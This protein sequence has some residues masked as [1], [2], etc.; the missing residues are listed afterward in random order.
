MVSFHLDSFIMCFINQSFFNHK[1]HDFIKESFKG[2]NLIVSYFQLV[3]I[4]FV[5]NWIQFAFVILNFDFKPMQLHS[6]TSQMLKL[7][8][9][10]EDLLEEF[11]LSCLDFRASINY[12]FIKFIVDY[13]MSN[14]IGQLLNY[15]INL[16]SLEFMILDLYDCFPQLF[17]YLLYY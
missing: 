6:H 3:F 2:E 5:K 17:N 13:W 1:I 10:L 16:F 4:V 9:W 15:F 14:I 7:M 12:L 11:I 8:Q